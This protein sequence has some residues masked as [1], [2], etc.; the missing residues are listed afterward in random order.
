MCESETVK[1]TPF[2]SLH[3]D[4]GAKFGPFAGYD[5]PLFYPLG[6]LKEHQHTRERAG[7]F[8][9]SHMVHIAVEG[10]Q[11]AA[12]I[13]RACPY[14]PA[15]Q[16]IGSGKYSFFL[17]DK[18]GIEDD[19]IVSRLGEERFLIVANAGCAE[20]DV[21]HITALSKDFDV[22]V[23]V[24]PRAFLALQGPQAEAVL[25]R[26]GIAVAAMEFMTVA[27]PRAGWFVS[28]S[29]Y[30]GEDGFE[31]GLPVD[32]G[33]ALARTLLA[34]EAVEWIGLGARDS[35]RL[36]AGLPLYGQDLSDTITPHEAGLIW[37]IPKPLREAGDYIGAA[38]LASAIAAGRRRKRIGLTPRERVPVRAGARLMNASGEAIGSVTSGGFG[39][40]VG[41]PVALGLVTMDG[42]EGA[43]FA[44]V[45]G[46]QIEM[47]KAAL[48]FAP[49][50][51]K[52]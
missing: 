41:G 17:N 32:Q 12:L 49:H 15:K 30:T 51:Y 14:E 19:L 39:P 33:E 40:T 16:A 2:H 24:L 43:I 26:A 10:P 21:A 42:D 37:A 38:A 44:D 45:R 9:I 28:R 50:R 5:M 8:D 47:E 36:E 27:E 20:K 25:E 1:Q 22:T 3:Q 52:R 48:P 34:D 13:G 18:G 46:K 7:L 6:I 23:T 4:A 11:A 31:I 35:L 29:G